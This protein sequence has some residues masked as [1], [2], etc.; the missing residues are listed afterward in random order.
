MLRQIERRLGAIARRKRLA[1][2]AVGLAPL[3]LRALLLPWLPV[4]SPR[5]QDE[6]SHLLVADTFAHGRLVNPVHPM[7]VHFE[8]MHILVRPVYASVFPVA[9]GV[10]MAAAQVLTGQPWIGVWLSVGFLCAA[11][12]WML[13]GWVSP[14]WAL[15]GGAL[16]VARFGVFSYWMNSYYGGAVAAAG[17][18]LVLGAL[19][20]ILRRRNWRDAALMGATLG[21][22]LAILANSRPYEGVLFALPALAAL[23]WLIRL[24]PRPLAILAPLLLILGATALLMGVYFVRVSG[25]PFQLPYSFYRGNF[26]MAPHFIFQSPR[27]EPVYHQRVLRD[28][29]TLW[30]MAAYNDA[31]ANRSPYGILDKAKTYWRFY[32]GPFLTIPFLA[33]PWLCRRRRTR[34]LLFAA[35][36]FSLGLAVEVWHAPHYAAPAMGLILLLVIQALRQLRQLRQ[37]RPAGGTF[38]VRAIVLAAVLTPVIGGGVRNSDGSER[39]RIVRELAAKGGRHLV[40]LRYQRTHDTG[41]EWVYNSA[42]IDRSPVVWAREMDPT[43]NR[44]LL[45]Y[46]PDR[47]VW[48]VQPDRKP[49]K[50]SPYDPSQPPDPPFRFFPMGTDAVDALRSPED[51]RRK[52]LQK[53]TAEYQPPYRFGCDTWAY[54]FTELTGVESPD[55]AHGCFPPGRRGRLVGFEE[56]FAWLEKQ[57]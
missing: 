23:L 55:V 38:A 32:L 37:P 18:A 57:R 14:G 2:L 47:Q 46:F 56:W 33:I 22:G 43:G 29:H 24:R 3:V 7:W 9:Q 41:D 49:V 28:F 8:S 11:L 16:A 34:L 30:E 31:R 48:L 53:V 4:P 1:I 26:T 20:R 54:F 45:R 13:Q 10:V 27:P 5:V 12:C 39:A 42:D 17:G 6:F 50:L 21:A 36:L 40:L 44:A 19:P 25:S 51:I 35:I 52:L 15:L